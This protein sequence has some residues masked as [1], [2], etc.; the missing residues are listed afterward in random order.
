MCKKNFPCCLLL[1]VLLFLSCSDIKINREHF[2]EE[3][4]NASHQIHIPDIKD[5]INIRYSDIFTKVDYIPLECTVQ[6]L[7]ANVNKLEILED[8]GYL[9]L[10]R[11]NSKVLRFNKDG[12]FVNKIGEVG[13]RHNEY[14]RVNDF[15]YLPSLQKIVIWDNPS[16][17]LLVYSLDGEFLFTKE[18]QYWNGTLERLEGDKIVLYTKGEDGDYTQKYVVMDIEGK[19]YNV[20]KDIFSNCVNFIL[21]DP[22]MHIMSSSLFCRSEYSPLV[23]EIK[24]N[25]FSPKY[26]IDFSGKSI[27]IE[28]MELNEN[29]F[30]EKIRSEHATYCYR[31]YETIDNYIMTLSKDKLYLYVCNKTNNKQAYA[32]YKVINDMTGISYY[33]ELK[34][35][36]GSCI[37]LDV[38]DNKCYFTEDADAFEIENK[39]VN[40][41][42]NFLIKNKKESLC[43]DSLSSEFIRFKRLSQNRNPVIIVGTLK[44]IVR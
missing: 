41:I 27:P 26:S 36:S 16:H 31:F 39:W 29:E 21:S 10:D 28:W 22:D 42:N 19:I 6:S 7:I 37:P 17:S 11:N 15:A 8:G 20:Y 35:F 38:K 25:S 23:Y 12:K 2:I 9:V 40:D 14:T 24:D 33:D 18:I 1:L 5:S 34:R 32:G 13:K 3:Y 4:T 43:L 30:R 44:S